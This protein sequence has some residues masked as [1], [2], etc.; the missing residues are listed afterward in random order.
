MIFAVD[1]GD[2]IGFALVDGETIVMMGSMKDSNFIVS[3]FVTVASQYK[4]NLVMEKQIGKE[5]EEYTEL[6][7]TLQ[8]VAKWYSV[9]IVTI[10]PSIWKNSYINCRKVSVS[11][12]GVDA[13]K[14]ALYVSNKLG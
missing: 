5:V 6:I 4:I 7:K 13:A 3:I 8:S 14:Q 10:H 2:T 1:W 12:H 11:N 9:D